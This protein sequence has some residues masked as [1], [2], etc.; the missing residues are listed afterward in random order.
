M[1]YTITD[2]SKVT[3]ADKIGTYSA[4]LVAMALP[5]ISFAAD[6]QEPDVSKV[7]TYIGYAV[8]AVVAIG[9]AKLI[10]AV[11]MWLYSSLGSM[12]KRG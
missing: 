1:K 11:A 8:G 12:A 5:V 3:I 2:V 6:L 10:P 4:I 7:T 9:S